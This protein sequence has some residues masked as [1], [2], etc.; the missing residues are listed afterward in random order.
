MKT[1]FWLVAKGWQTNRQTR[2][3]PLVRDMYV[4]AGSAGLHILVLS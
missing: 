1:D 4:C 3:L 2:P